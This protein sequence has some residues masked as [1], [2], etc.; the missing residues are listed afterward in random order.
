M[1]LDL[2][3]SSFFKNKVYLF[4]KGFIYLLLERGREKE[5]SVCGCFLHAPYW[6]PG[7]QLRHVPWL[8]IEP[9]TL[10]FASWHSIHWATIARATFS[11][12]HSTSSFRRLCK[13][14]SIL[15]I[16][17]SYPTSHSF[18]FKVKK[19]AMDSKKQMTLKWITMCQILMNK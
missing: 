13:G 10:L 5:T 12:Y 6:G 9:G 3:F 2:T 8:G 16:F 15:S 19:Y 7:L 11:S 17:L 14:V 4:L 1:I 18:F